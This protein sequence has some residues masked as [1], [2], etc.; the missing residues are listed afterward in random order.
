[1]TEYEQKIVMQ[2]EG[3]EQYKYP[4]EAIPTNGVG[5]P[6]AELKNPHAAGLDFETFNTLMKQ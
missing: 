1:M 6:F 5:F 4:I 2:N 3:A